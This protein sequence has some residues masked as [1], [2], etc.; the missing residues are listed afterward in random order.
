MHDAAE[1]L[2]TLTIVLATAAVTTVVFQR[3]RQP[4][5]LGYIIAGLII[6]PHVPIP[7]V[8]D[9]EVVE[10]LSELGVILLMFSLGLEFSLAKLVRVGPTAGVTAVIQSAIMA[11]LGFM[12]GRA[13]GWSV[14]ESVFAGAVI[15]ISS[16]TIIAKVFEE[17]RIRGRMREQV[18]GILLIE[19][20]I[21]ILLMA[22]LTAV[23]SGV[24]LSAG[25]FARTVGVLLAFLLAMLVLGML[26][27]P[28]FVR[29]VLRFRRP[30]TTLVASIGICFAMAYTAHEAGYSVALGAFMAGTLV[31]ESGY[32][33]EIEH[34]IVPVRDMFLAIFFVSVGILIDPAL[35]LEYWPAVLVFT[36]VVILGKIGGVAFGSFLT[37]SG[38]RTSVQAGMSLAQIGEFSFIIAG[39]GVSLGAAREFLFPV[40]VAVS[41]ITTLSTPW[42]IRAADPVSEY[43]DRKLPRPL[44]TLSALYGAWLERLR[45]GEAT[46][47]GKIRHKVS[48][49]AL[50][51][52]LL[53]GLIIAVSVWLD[54]AA[55]LLERAVGLGGDVARV[56]VVAVGAALSL[57]LVAGIGGICRR[58]GM[59]LAAA[60]LPDAEG[61]ADLDAAPRRALVLVLELGLALLVG[62]VVLAVTQPFL[63][64]YA[65]P[66][67]LGALL[68]GFGIAIWRS[69]ADLQGQVRAGAQVVA[70]ALAAHARG[71]E[72][73]RPDWQ[74]QEIPRL[75]KGLGAPL[76]V[77]L[78]DT[79]P[80]VGR[81]LAQLNLR[82]RTGATVL[83]ILRAGERVLIPAA[84]E[85]LQRG[86]VLALAGTEEALE[87]AREI[88]L[89]PAA[90]QAPDPHGAAAAPA[91]D[92]LPSR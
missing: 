2:R 52:G 85:L 30:E 31:S 90:A 18:V 49:L 15:A 58:L 64:S 11:W 63:P 29:F 21:A 62:V 43:V 57:P 46:L 55:A 10:T 8:A 48:L 40:A 13:F 35:V 51:A 5:V 60:A 9:V 12:V 67:V 26:I 19:D 42:L 70:E 83:A 53:A 22:G 34:L 25:A 78:R 54:E 39:L 7:L 66:I 24:G 37:G 33:D 81:T 80:A 38:V 92:V 56:L 76:A 61:K 17:Q 27:V 89:G 86:D 73:A 23:A 71:G 50:D 91:T 16:T 3:L 4:V 65:G 87:A 82:G 88:L 45:A 74:I 69:A 14:L 59:T 36:A 41:A 20:L 28:R 79:C 75:L 32:G 6:G 84:G 68:I 44:Q 77:E 1:F 47:S 72:D